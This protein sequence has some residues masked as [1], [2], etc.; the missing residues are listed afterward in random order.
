M[1]NE[2]FPNV[3]MDDLWTATYETLY[4][5]VISVIGTFILGI[6][7]GLVLYFDR[8]RKSLEQPGLVTESTANARQRVP[9]HPVH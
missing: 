2:L 4:M 5:T 9:C 7:L 6:I 8:S 1:L 3:I